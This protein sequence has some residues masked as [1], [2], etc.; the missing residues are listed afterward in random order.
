V[1]CV[2]WHLRAGAALALAAAF[3]AADVLIP[4]V[5]A[6]DVDTFT[7]MPLDAGFGPLDTSP[8]A[9]PPDEI[10]KRFA[11]KESE[12]K[13]A[14]SHYTWRREARVQTINDASSSPDGEW[15]EIDDVTFDPDGNRIE[16]TV[17]APASTLRRIMLTPSDMQDI[18]NGYPMVLT[19]DEVPAYDI[20]FVGRQKVDEVN[21]YVFDVS[22]KQ[23]LKNH[24][25][26]LGRIWVEDEGFQIVVTNG[27]MVP[28]GTKKGEQDLHPPFMAWREQ[29]DG[30]Y[31]FPTYVRGEGILHFAAGR[32]SRGADIHVREVIKFTR[33]KRVGPVGG[34]HSRASAP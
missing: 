8:P 14:V 19:T 16:S 7:P 21:C 12:F 30:L 28:D 22:P 4:P 17:Y 23:I 20:N 3:V 25:Y 27:R 13:Q 29:I 2:S 9:T 1:T 18:R 11:A 26:L 15:A 5:A 33:Y 31:W 34:D 6:Q 32:R 10:I 24:R